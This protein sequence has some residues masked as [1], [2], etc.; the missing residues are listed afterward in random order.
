MYFLPQSSHE[1]SRRPFTLYRTDQSPSL[2]PSSS[3][4]HSLFFLLHVNLQ[5]K[6]HFSQ[7]PEL[8]TD[9]VY[10]KYGC[11]V[12]VGATYPLIYQAKHKALNQLS[13][14]NSPLCT[15][16][17]ALYQLRSTSLPLPTSLQLNS[18][19]CRFTILLYKLY[20]T[21]WSFPTNFNTSTLPTLLFQ[22]Q[23]HS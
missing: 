4:S 12:R 1:M 8:E 17:T 11:F 20:F 3:L 23:L 13:F 18:T 22:F 5:L 14:S 16:P 6:E 9:C 15:L 19:K 7:C 10:K 2:P 21:K